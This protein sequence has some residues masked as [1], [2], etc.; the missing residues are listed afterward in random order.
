MTLPTKPGLPSAVTGTKKKPAPPAKKAKT[1]LLNLGAPPPPPASTTAG[2][3]ENKYIAWAKT[4]NISKEQAGQIWYWSHA[5]GLAVDP[6]YWSAVLVAE[7]GLNSN[8]QKNSSGQAMGTAQIATSW[9][10]T[11]IPW[12]PKGVLFTDDNNPRT[13]LAN[14]SVNLRFGTYL[15]HSAVVKNGYTNAYVKG[16]NP[17]DPNRN[18]ANANI[19]RILGTR[20]SN[21]PPLAPNTGEADTSA[22]TGGSTPYPTF[23]DEYVA[24]VTKYNKFSLTNDPNKALQYDGAP[25]TRSNF[26]TLKDQ[27]TSNYVSYTGQRPSNHQIQ[28]YID[29]GWNT[30]TLATLL[31]KSKN[32]QTS[33]IYKQ[34][35]TAMNSTLKDVL[36]AGGKIPEDIARQAVLN[37]WDSTTV[38]Q[39]LRAL[40]GYTSSEEFKGNVATLENVQTSIMGTPDAT[41]MQSIQQAALAGW[42]SDQYAA[43]LR[44]QPAYTQSPEYQTKALGFLGALGLITGSTPV[45]QPGVSNGPGAVSPTLGTLPNDP[46]IK[47]TPYSSPGSQ[48]RAGIP[49]IPGLG[50]TL[51]G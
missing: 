23:K 33:P 4:H 44:S 8:G 51:S 11:Q 13:G 6:Y 36:P 30:Y 43:W 27:L 47:P 12:E 5:K 19:N 45:L 37:S 18:V 9:I 35:I 38:A 48:N 16:Y 3:A 46:R 14:F 1:G 2:T 41:A 28:T 24:G 15:I 25:L 50:A 17:N 26:L 22:S 20:P 49:A 29:K 40:P 7:G 32:F 34:T 10:G 21:L 39:K 42:T 31:S